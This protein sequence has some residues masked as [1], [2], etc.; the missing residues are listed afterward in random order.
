MLRKQGIKHWSR[1]GDE[2][3][4]LSNQKYP[5]AACRITDCR[6]IKMMI[7]SL[8]S[9][10][11]SSSS[12]HPP[13]VCVWAHACCIL[14]CKN[15][16]LHIFVNTA[17]FAPIRTNECDGCASLK[18]VCAWYQREKAG[19]EDVAQG[20]ATFIA[21]ILVRFIF[22]VIFD[23]YSVSLFCAGSAHSQRGS[24]FSLFSLLPAL[25]AICE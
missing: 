1:D 10:T 9:H 22:I 15:K 14:R 16:R 17:A 24:K 11:S 3:L 5:Q 19:W 25:A 8:I 2:T 7:N 12:S 21:V 18:P 23:F 6:V 4:L 13:C 20:H